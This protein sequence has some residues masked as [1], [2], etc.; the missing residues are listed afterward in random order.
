MDVGTDFQHVEVGYTFDRSWQ[1]RAFVRFDR[2]SGDR[3]PVDGRDQ[4]FD[5]LYGARRFELGPTGIYGAFARSNLIAHAYGLSARP[6]RHLAVAGTFGVF[7]LATRKDAWTTS[8]LRDPSGGA[9]RD[10]GRQVEARVVCDVRP[11]AVRLEAGAAALLA[12]A[13]MKAAGKSDA[14]YGYAQAVFAFQ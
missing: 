12:G 13:F 8:G 2:A 3:E 4:R 10:L 7:A 5:T 11:G 6:H 1:P 9:G 14:E